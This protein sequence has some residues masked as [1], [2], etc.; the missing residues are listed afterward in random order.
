[1]IFWKK[2]RIWLLILSCSSTLLVLGKVILLPIP[3][4]PKVG[5][6]IFPKEVPLAKW[7]LSATKQLPKPADE[8]P[9]LIALWHYQYTQKGQPLDIEMRYLQDNASVPKLI[10]SFYQASSTPIVRQHPGVG[11]YG[12]GV[13]KQNRAYLS[14][15]INPR[16]SSTFT[17]TEFI[18]NRYLYDVRPDRLVNLML[19]KE[20]L[21][22]KRCVW[23]HLSVPLNG[24]SPEAAY[25]VL[26]NAWFDWHKW[27][28]LNFPKV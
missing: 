16:G 22:D 7:K 2:V 18:T 21:L 4:K 24:S 20:L 14:A 3:D 8:I 17:Q 19:G 26:E 27:W 9:Q 23:A 13:D 5:A 15:C 25:Q 12:L 28:Q 11:K 10:R 1:M 6:F